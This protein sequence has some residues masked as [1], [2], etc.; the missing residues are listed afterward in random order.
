MVNGYLESINQK[1]TLL[2]TS[3]KDFLIHYSTES[4]YFCSFISLCLQNVQDKTSWTFVCLLFG[5]PNFLYISYTLSIYACLS[6]YIL[7]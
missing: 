6:L 3:N 7:S 2:F 1:R 5:I 4:L